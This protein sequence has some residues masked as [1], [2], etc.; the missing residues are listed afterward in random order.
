LNDSK[1]GNSKLKSTKNAA[2]YRIT[3]SAH[4]QCDGAP[5]PQNTRFSDP[6]H[7]TRFWALVVFFVVLQCM[8]I[9]RMMQNRT[10]FWRITYGVLIAL[11]IA[12][13]TLLI[14]FERVFNANSCS[15]NYQI[16]ADVTGI[17]PDTKKPSSTAGFF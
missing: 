2:L 11:N 12:A 13:F 8:N 10:L 1:A 3:I 14:A 6:C 16:N 7:A 4:N 5:I 17:G 15:G 9:F